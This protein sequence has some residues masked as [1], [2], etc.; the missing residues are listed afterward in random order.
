[1]V[2]ELLVAGDPAK[3]GAILLHLIREGLLRA[4]ELSGNSAVGDA[5][6]V[7]LPELDDGCLLYTSPSPRDS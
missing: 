1:M 7:I 6:R 5:F 4:A 3:V 2:L